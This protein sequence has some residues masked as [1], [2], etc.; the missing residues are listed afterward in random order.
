MPSQALRLSVWRSEKVVQKTLEI[1]QRELDEAVATL[2]AIAQN[3][4][5]GEERK[6]LTL[7][8]E[9]L[10][11]KYAAFKGLGKTTSLG[12]LFFMAPKV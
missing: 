4:R 8:Q 6:F 9:Q 1:E 12:E 2:F 7:R 10:V 3:Q 11:F 5:N